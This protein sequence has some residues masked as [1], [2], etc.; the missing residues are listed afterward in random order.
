[1]LFTISTTV[2]GYADS[3]SYNQDQMIQSAMKKIDLNKIQEQ[4]RQVNQDNQLS[5]K[6][7][8]ITSIPSWRSHVFIS[9]A[10]INNKLDSNILIEQINKYLSSNNHQILLDTQINELIYTMNKIYGG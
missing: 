9:K 2:N 8:Q 3:I 5:A 6:I 4:Q 10:R 1:M 7:Y